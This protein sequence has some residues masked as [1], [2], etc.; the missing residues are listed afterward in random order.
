MKL[1][2]VVALCA[3]ACRSKSGDV[4]HPTNGIELVSPGAEPRRVLHYAA[5]KGTKATLELA[6]DS[7]LSAGDESSAAP[8]LALGFELLVTDVLP[9]GQMK[10][11]MTVIDTSAKERPDSPMPATATDPARAALRGLVIEGLL[12]AD[13]KLTETHLIAA[14]G[15][16]AGSGSGGGGSGSG[17]SGG[18]G[19]AGSGSGSGGSGGSGSGAAGSNG[20]G[21]AGSAG[22]G[23]VGS[24]SAAPPAVAPAADPTQE[25]D[26]IVASFSRAVRPL[27]DVPVGVGAQWR[28]TQS[29]DASGLKMFA[30]N[31]T[32]VTKL[33]GD[34]LGYTATATLSGPDQVVRI[35]GTP[36][37]VEHLAGSAEGHGTVDLAKLLFTGDLSATVTSE[38]SAADERTP[39]K[40]TTKLVMTPR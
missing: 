21:A 17:S 31:T 22:S 35:E 24:G 8:T 33:A 11:R 37:H 29:I 30:T 38:M 5:P 27:P 26:E 16:G 20:S 12:S 23:G 36:I 40:M 3:T 2:L 6:L 18:G 28:S 7:S 19:S 1:A 10:L 9:T 34:E 39:M 14:P 25:L 4:A 13:G 15:G 32:I